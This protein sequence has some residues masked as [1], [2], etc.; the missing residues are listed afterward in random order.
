MEFLNI[1]RLENTNI[2]TLEHWTLEHWSIRTLEHL[3]IWIFEHLN[4]GTLEHWNI[5]TLENLNIGSLEHWNIGTF[6]HL[7]I[8]TFEHLNIWTRVWHS[9]KFCHKWIYEYICI[10]KTTQMNVW[11]YSYRKIDTNEYPN[12]YLYCKLYKCLSIFKYSIS[13]CTLTHSGTNV[14]IYSFKQT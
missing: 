10:K 4:I 3:N 11:K 7:N 2:G 14:R 13:F 5:R 12:K 6:E 1:G 9:W 8:W